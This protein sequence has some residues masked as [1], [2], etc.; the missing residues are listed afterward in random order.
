MNDGSA[1]CTHG[2]ILSADLE[3]ART[4]SPRGREDGAEVEVECHD[5]AVR[6][7]GVRENNRIRS[8]RAANNG[9]VNRLETA[10]FQKASPLR[11]QV[12]VDEYLHR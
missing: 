7:D 9:P 2:N 11:G 3:D 6:G 5:Y 12:H 4:K 8:R 1:D 10:P